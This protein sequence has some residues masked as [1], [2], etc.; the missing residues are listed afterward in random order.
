MKCCTTITALLL[1]AGLSGQGFNVVNLPGNNEASRGVSVREVPEGFLVF[2]GKYDGDLVYRA[3]TEMHAADGSLLWERP[4]VGTSSS[5]FGVFDPISDPLPDGGYLASLVE[6]ADD[7]QQWKACRFDAS[8]DTVWTRSL[9]TSYQV[10]ARTA[11]YQAGNYYVSALVLDDETDVQPKAVVARLDEQGTPLGSVEFPLIAYDHLTLSAGQDGD[12]LLAGGRAGSSF[13]NL[14][15]VYRLDEELNIIWSRNIVSN[16]PGWQDYTADVSKIVSDAEG[17]VLVSGTCYDEYTS[18][19]I[20]LAEFFIVKLARGNGEVLWTR[21]YPVS[22]SDWGALH[23][24]E[25][26][27]NGDMIACGNTTPSEQAGFLGCIYKYSDNGNQLWRRYYRFLT[28]MDAFNDLV[29]VEPLT[30]GGFI[31]TGTTRLSFQFPSVLW[32]LRLDEYG[33][34]EPGCQNVG[35]NEFYMGMPERTLTCAPNPVDEVL[36]VNVELP[37][38]Y[39]PLGPMRIEVTDLAGRVV[40]LGSLGSGPVA[41]TTLMVEGWQAGAYIIH[42]ADGTTL[43]TSRKFIVE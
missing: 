36:T 41:S 22:I 6:A 24:M 33:C 31:L 14:S 2:S 35:V 29:D 40:H 42:L 15:T 5:S 26:L 28:N 10:F 34:L 11:T 7:T 12:V 37:E 30:G 25:V 17:N 20:S 43:L 4:W 9:Q 18:P 23:D 32:L 27:P 39:R 3:H 38:A 1:C 16:I 19:G 13:P 8:G 21:R